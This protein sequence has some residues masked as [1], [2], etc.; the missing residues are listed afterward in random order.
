MPMAPAADAVTL[1][2]DGCTDVRQ[3]FGDVADRRHGHLQE[4]ELRGPLGLY[5][6][7]QGGHDVLD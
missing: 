1:V 3:G 5:L 2:G 6:G 4:G 7:V